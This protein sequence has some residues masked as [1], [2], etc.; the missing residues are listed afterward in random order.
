LIQHWHVSSN[1]CVHTIQQEHNDLYALEFSNDGQLFAVAGEDT[2]VY[3]YDEATRQL[4]TTFH[5]GRGNHTGHANRVFTLKFHPNDQNLLMSGGWDRTIQLY[6]VRAGTIIGSIFGPA[7]SGDALDVHEDLIV[8]GSN[9]N[10]DVV[11]L[12]SLSKR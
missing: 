7:I 6:D 4:I 3:L 10:K 9:R 12:F 11:Q 2:R 5:E 8:A 1:K